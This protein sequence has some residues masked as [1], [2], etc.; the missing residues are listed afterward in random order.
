MYTWKW[1]CT[2]AAAA[3]LAGC[4]TP[5]KVANMQGKGDRRVYDAP[6]DQAW[7]AAIDAT[8]RGGLEITSANR[9]TGYISA[10][11]TVRPHTFGENVGVWVRSMGPAQTE[12]EV[13]SRQAGPPVTWFSNWE[14]EIHTS[15]AA[16]LTR[17]PA[18]GSPPGQ[19]RVIIPEGTVR[20]GN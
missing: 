13:V 17:E 6:F 16:N 8:Q 2:G 19:T 11:R 4:A 7:R 14:N 1:I 10:R 5:N 9:E 20:E 15:I 18:V 3:L 12:L